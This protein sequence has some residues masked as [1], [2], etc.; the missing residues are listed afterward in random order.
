MATHF[1]GV[2][3]IFTLSIVRL[4]SKLPHF[5]GL[6]CEGDL[7]KCRMAHTW[8][9]LT[10]VG[11]F[12]YHAKYALGEVALTQCCCRAVVEG[13]RCYVFLAGDKVPQI[14]ASR[15]GGHLA[16]AGRNSHKSAHN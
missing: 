2:A 5:G 3:T 16:K 9:A 8:C 1:W 4:L 13:K 10:D 6:F 7:T 14:R 15:A 11:N 12:S